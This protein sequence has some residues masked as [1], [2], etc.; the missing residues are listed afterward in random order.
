VRRKIFLAAEHTWGDSASVT[1]PWKPAAVAGLAGKQTLM[2]EAAYAATDLLRGALPA[3]H[4]MFDP[5]LEGFDPHWARLADGKRRT[6]TVRAL[7]PRYRSGRRVDWSP[8]LSGAAPRVVVEQPADG[9]RAT[10]YEPGQFNRP[11]AHGRW[12]VQPRWRRR[13]CRSAAVE[14]VVDG[15]TLRIEVRVTLPITT[16][17]RSLY[18]EFPFCIAVTGAWAEVGGAWAD[19][20]SECVPGSCV[21]WWTVHQ[22]VLLTGEFGSVLWTAWD[23]PLVMFDA[24]CPNPPKRS[25][26]LT[27]PVLISWALNTYWTTNFAALSGGDY[28]FRYRLKY[29][30]R[31]V[32]PRE[33]ERFCAGDPL[34]DYPRLAAGGT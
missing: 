22:G 8:L 14:R 20:R 19:P 34:A 2:Y 32:T 21:N 13:V 24:I 11:E 9:R 16:A 23:A 15:D 5:Q 7:C 3:Q 12:P 31:P 6:E 25:N 10:W 29:W 28:R 1:A 27:P 26:T 18:V 33:A 30:P 4:V 17:P